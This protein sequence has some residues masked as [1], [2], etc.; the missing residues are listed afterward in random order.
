VFEQDEAVTIEI[1]DTGTDIPPEV[2]DS[3]FD[4]FYTTK[5]V[6]KGLGLGLSISYNIVKD[7]RGEISAANTEQGGTR[8]TLSFQKSVG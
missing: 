1:T 2:K 6:G 5:E 7:M 8:F 4:P 3:I